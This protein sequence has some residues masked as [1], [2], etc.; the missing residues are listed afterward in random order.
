MNRTVT[1]GGGR[2]MVPAVILGWLLLVLSPPVWAETA[3]SDSAGQAYEQGVK[4]S[5][6]KQYQAAI[7]A[8]TKALQSDPN[9]PG[10]LYSLGRIYD[11]QGKTKEARALLE[12]LTKIDPAHAD[13]W[14]LLGRLAEKE[15][16]LK[17]A[18]DGYRMALAAK[19]DLVDAHYNLGFVYLSMER[20]GDAAKQFTEVLRLNPAYAEA[21]MNLGVIYTAQSKLDEAEKE[22][23]A[24]V[25]LKPM[26]AEAHY[27]LGVFF[28]FHRKDV[29]KAL[30]QYRKYLELG[31]TDE[32]V[33]RIIRQLGGG[34]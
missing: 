4:L 11:G 1:E 24:A 3:K 29:G 33:E 13:G 34:K 10:A 5:E 2:V 6:A 19:P 8:L 15:N 22:Y 17:D 9:H 28:E 31:G 21:H 25:T 12:R 7:E 32:R 18:M 20:R 14:Y 30:A 26:L 23:E 27:N 16:R